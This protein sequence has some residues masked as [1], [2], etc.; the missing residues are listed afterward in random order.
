[1]NGRKPRDLA[2][3]ISDQRRNSVSRILLS[4]LCAVAGTYSLSAQCNARTKKVTVVIDLN[5]NPNSKGRSVEGPACVEVYFNPLYGPV[6]LQTNETRTPGPDLGATLGTT[7]KA[8]KPATGTRLNVVIFAPADAAVTPPTE[9]QKAFET[10]RKTVED[11]QQRAN[12]LS[13]DWSAAL[14]AQEQ[15]ISDLKNLLNQVAGIDP[16]TPALSQAVE[17]IANAALLKHVDDAIDKQLSYHPSDS[18]AAPLLP[19]LHKL[20]SQLSALPIEYS[21]GSSAWTEWYDKNKAAYDALA[22]SIQDA[23]DT[24]IPYATGKDADKALRAKAG[25]VNYWKARLDALGIKT[26]ATVNL[27]PF[28]VVRVNVLCSGVFNF[29]SSTAISLVLIDQRPTLDGNAPTSKTLDPFITVT[30]ASR[31][32]VTA[33]AGFS[34]IQQKSFAIVKSAGGQNGAAVNKFGTLSDSRLNPMPMALAHARF[35]DSDGHLIGWHSTFG[36]AGKFQGQESG[37]S[38]AEFLIGSSVSIARAVYFSFGLHIGTRSE[39]AGGYH[40]NDAVPA[41]IT[42]LQGQ[43]KHSYTPGFGFAISFTKP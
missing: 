40:E 23:I 42:S 41:E 9:I 22:K 32:S 3:G 17:S 30:C 10:I 27:L 6:T 35:W 13:T 1:M 25:I 4:F 7:A 19:L 29:N 14:T 16:S 33:G 38:A 36:V 21:N 20:Q 5:G 11:A 28:S 12:Q 18:A 26:G 43:V 15:V 34:T 24:A 2:A 39:L 31:I 8:E 37:G